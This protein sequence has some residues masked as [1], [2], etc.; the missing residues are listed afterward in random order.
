[1]IAQALFRAAALAVVLATPA[2]ALAADPGGSVLSPNLVNS[3]VTLVVFLTLL[4][5]LWKF[6]W[7]PILKSL[8]ARELAQ[9]RA[10]DEAK[11]AQEDAAALR[12]QFEAEMAKAADQV[13]GIMEEARRDA[14]ALRATEREAGARDAQAER[15]RAKR[16]IEGAKEVA[17]KEIYEQ[18]VRLAAL[19]SEKALRR[20][21]SA[22]D[23]RRLFDETLADLKA[24]G[25]A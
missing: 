2:S 13:R 11:K 5:V 7:G 23:H 4:A 17:L 16:E 8:E 3:A 21:V 24:G 15:E 10:L 22:D 19:M 20:A 18:A 1:M 14:E 9:F 12:R 25:K 6:A